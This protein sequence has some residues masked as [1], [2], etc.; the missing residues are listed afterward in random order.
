GNNTSIDLSSAMDGSLSQ[1]VDLINA[2][3]ANVTAALN[4]AG[5][6]L[7]ITDT[8]GGSG[9]LIIAGNA[10]A[11]LGIDTAGVASDTRRG[12]DLALRY[13][14]EATRLGDLNYGRG[15]GLGTFR[16][17]DGVGQQF[18][19]SIGKDAKNVYD[20]ISEFNGQADAAG[21]KVAARVNDTGDGIVL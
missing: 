21:A 10:A 9:N 2:S 12:D 3:G 15:I 8:S 5:N 20:I 11:E 7:L 4:D 18:T 13:V 17:T 1:V 6:G 14:S 16:V 19:V